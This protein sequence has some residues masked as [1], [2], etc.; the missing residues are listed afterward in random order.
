MHQESLVEYRN[1]V[2]NP[3]SPF[4]NP[5]SSP[6][7]VLRSKCNSPYLSTPNP[8]NPLRVKFSYKRP[9]S[10]EFEESL[11]PTSPIKKVKM[12]M[13]KEDVDAS[14]AA[15]GESLLKQFIAAQET[16][17][18]DLK[19]DIKQDI[20]AIK[21][22]IDDLAE[23]QE[24]TAQESKKDKEDTD[25]RIKALED[26]F[27]VF[28]Y[29]PTPKATEMDDDTIQTAVRN[30][31]DSSS[32]NSWK[33]GLAREILDHEHGLIVHGVRF[34]GNDDA[35][36]RNSAYKF[37]KEDL[38]A[39]EDMLKRVK[40][41]EVVRLGA[42]NGAGKPPPLLIKFNH[43]TERNLLLPLSR[44]LKNGVDVD[45][46]VPKMYQKKHREFKKLAWKFKNVHDVQTQVIFDSYNLVLRYIKHDDGASKYNW[47]IEKEY[48]P[49]P[50][51]A[52]TV[53]SR[54]TT[55]DP[56]KQDSP[57][58]DAKGEC[59]K[60]LIVTGLCDTINRTNVGEEFKI[61][62]DTKDH[63]LLVKVDYKSKGTAII[64]CREWAGCKS[65]AVNYEKRKMLN[66]DIVFTLF[67][68]A[69]PTV[70]V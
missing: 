59:N 17:G 4:P 27:D 51:D 1:Q 16:F 8:E 53:Q 15:M 41:R 65:I 52:E 5:T 42:D 24:K 56:N 61:Y 60:T 64:I 2:Y 70:S 63:D 20:G 23:K 31:V 34:E 45:K 43:P 7:K 66:K 40:I 3:G 48:Y 32:E 9:R 29:Q 49:K 50:G 30:I 58:V 47:I 6:L 38:K 37:L 10:L 35:A 54:A 26:K 18:K 46:S 21:G 28:L 67:S 44:N 62:L 12:T 55:R 69:D 39:S 57:V 14:M 13:K 68:E 11:S 36:R 25:A 19:E 33:A 22:T